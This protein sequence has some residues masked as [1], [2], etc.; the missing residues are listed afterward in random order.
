METVLDVNAGLCRLSSAGSRLNDAVWF[1]EL[2][3][4]VSVSNLLGTLL[5]WIDAFLLKML[6]EAGSMFHLPVLSS[7]FTFSI[8]IS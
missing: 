4:V 3:D 2:D 5:L 7:L 8:N 6:V 1:F